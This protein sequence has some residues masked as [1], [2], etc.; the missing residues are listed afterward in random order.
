MIS[1]ASAG[2]TL[3]RCRVTGSGVAVTWAASMPW[4]VGERVT[5]VMQDAH[6]LADRERALVRYP[7]AQ[8]LARD[9]RHDVVEQVALGSGGEQRDDVGMLQLGRELDLA[10][11]SFSAHARR[12]LGRQHLHHHATAEADLLGE[13]D[14]AHAAAAELTFDAVGGA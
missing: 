6:R 1:D 12:Q 8:R 9:V 4:G 7:G 3:S 11:E 10:L 2:G 5:D 13:E 14:A